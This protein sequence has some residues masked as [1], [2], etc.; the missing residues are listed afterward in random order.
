MAERQRAA[1]KLV[2]EA[3]LDSGLRRQQRPKQW[4]WK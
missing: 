4:N 3:R 1:G 2:A